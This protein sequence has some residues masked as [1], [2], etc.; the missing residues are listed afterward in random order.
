VS[1]KKSLKRCGARNNGHQHG[2][3]AH[4]EKDQQIQRPKAP[5]ETRTGLE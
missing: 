3:A 5:T 4:F 2:T 1:I